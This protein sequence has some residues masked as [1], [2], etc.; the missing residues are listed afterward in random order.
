M[1]YTALV[2]VKELNVAKSRLAA[3]LSRQQRESLVLDMLHHVL[4]I[5]LAS[6]LFE[7]VSVVSPDTRVLENAR[8]WGAQALKEEQH[9]HKHYPHAPTTGAA[10]PVWLEQ[11]TTLP[12]SG[13]TAK[14][15]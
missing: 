11:S 13:Q 4:Q 15:E 9:G 14:A 2:P 1:T 10:L 12:T 3:Y 6:C 7:R 5:L 8:L